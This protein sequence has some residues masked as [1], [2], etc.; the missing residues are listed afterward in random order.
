MTVAEGLQAHSWRVTL[1]K[2]N[3]STWQVSTIR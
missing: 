2:A 1:I 3:G